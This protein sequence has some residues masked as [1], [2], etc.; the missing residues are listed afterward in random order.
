MAISST[1]LAIRKQLDHV[2]A[3]R[4][5]F[6][7]ALS[8]RVR[9]WNLVDGANNEPYENR[10]K[11]AKVTA[12]DDDLD[13]ANIGAIV[14]EWYN[15]NINYMNYELNLSTLDAYLSDRRFRV[16]EHMAY[17]HYRIAFSRLSVDNVFPDEALKFGEVDYAAGYTESAS[18]TDTNVGPSQVAVE[19]TADIGATYDFAVDLTCNVDRD[20]TN[21][22]VVSVSI[23]AGSA[24]G[25]KRVA[26]RQ[27]LTSGVSA[28]ATDISV[29]DAGDFVANEV[30][31]I[32]E[33]D[34]QEYGVVSS[35]TGTTITLSEGIKHDYTTA[36]TITP[37]FFGVPS[38]SVVSGQSGDKADVKVEPDRVVSLS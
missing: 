3:L 21:Q 7:D 12:V 4:R 15:L 37:C 17:I 27:A 22:V 10:V 6:K 36:A 18:I 16:N 35:V 1:D 14:S 13:A 5:A 26:A 28:G 29:A 32:E 34:T 20:G 24:S 9:L 30:V 8:G 11:G 2:A 23:P 19:A 25:T 38:V 31:I 33:G